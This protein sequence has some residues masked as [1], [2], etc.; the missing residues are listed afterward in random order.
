M[1]SLYFNEDNHHFYGYHPAED[2]TEEGCRRLIETYAETGTIK[3]LLFCA[4][5][6][7]A[8]FDSDQW[9]RFRD[10]DDPDP[11]VQNLRLLTERGVDQ[12]AVWLQ[13]SK[14]LGIE[15]WLTMRMNDSHGLKEAETGTA[16][17]IDKW[18]S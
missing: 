1:K 18:P 8:L 15:G 10:I 6:Q 7:R 16:H 11:Y 3:G 17:W 9:E 4:N 13:R 14:K 12:F 5:V 2:M